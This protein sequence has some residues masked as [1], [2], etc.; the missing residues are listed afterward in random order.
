MGLRHPPLTVQQILAW[1]D[2]HHAQT[3]SWPI[4]TTGPVLANPKETW[5]NV[6]IALRIGL[7]K[8]PGGSSLANLLATER[9]VR[10][11]QDLPR[12]TKRQIVG[13]ARSHHQRTERWPTVK[14]GP[15]IDAPGVT[16][17]A[18]AAAKRKPLQ[19]L[20]PIRVRAVKSVAPPG[21]GSRWEK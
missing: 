17:S 3:G 2:D 7:R 19:A 13:W 20:R 12:L 14:A 5:R 1:A 10:N 6:D 21:R 15:V 18:I 4:T 8:L 9:G 11:V 16:W